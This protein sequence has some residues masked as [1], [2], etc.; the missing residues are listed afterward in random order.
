MREG[1]GVSGGGGG[2]GGGGGEGTVTRNTGRFSL[3]NSLASSGI[4]TPFGQTQRERESGGIVE[5]KKK[6]KKK[7]EK[8]G[9]SGIGTPMSNGS[10]SE[11]EEEEE[12]GEEGMSPLS[13]RRGATQQEKKH[14]KMLKGLR[15]S[16]IRT[17]GRIKENEEMYR[18]GG[19][20]GSGG[21]GGGGGE[22]GRS[23]KEEKK[24]K[25]QLSGNIGRS[26]SAMGSREMERNRERERDAFQIWM[27]NKNEL[28]GS[29]Y[30]HALI[31]LDDHWE[32]NARKKDVK[33]ANAKLRRDE[34]IKK[35]KSLKKQMKEK[36][37][38]DLI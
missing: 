38:S 19:G 34:K 30:T 14:R 36:K 27:H 17:A 23:E 6:K 26:I 11:M 8:L 5:K 4:R 25:V 35:K 20:S 21:S 24:K 31:H 15:Y 3:R 37:E 18:M 2:G 28:S 10:G 33:E 13:T 7:G 29:L 16:L 9:S 22:S 12:E 32:Y 1:E